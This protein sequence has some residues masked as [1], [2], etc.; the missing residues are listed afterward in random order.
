VNEEIKPALTAAQWATLRNDHTHDAIDHV[1]RAADKSDLPAVMA[2]ANAAFP[3]T[4]P[5]KL[6]REDYEVLRRIGT[7]YFLHRE[8]TTREEFVV[9]DRALGKLRALL[10]PEA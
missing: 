3:D 6:A 2:L 8:G 5:R 10:P 9:A 7:W 1:R 4:D